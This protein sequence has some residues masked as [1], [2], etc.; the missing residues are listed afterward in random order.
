LPDGTTSH[1]GSSE[2]WLE[3]T[4]ELAAYTNE[5]LTLFFEIGWHPE[6]KIP[7][8]VQDIELDPEW[9]AT[10]SDITIQGK[11]ALLVKN[12]ER[13]IYQGKDEPPS[14][15]PADFFVCYYLDDHTEVVIRAPASEWNDSEF[16]AAIS[17]VKVTPPAGYY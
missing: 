9:T 3:T 6:K 16:K 5:N 12:K 4:F 1:V 7:S 17:S 8:N 2:T 13:K 14:I 10:R 11:K 15:D